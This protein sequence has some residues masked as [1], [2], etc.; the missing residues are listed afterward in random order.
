MLVVGG[1]AAGALGG[2]L[3][4]V[5]GR[6]SQASTSERLAVYPCPETGPSL[7]FISA[8]QQVL[9]T[10]RNEASTWLRIHYPSSGRQEAWVEAGPMTVDGSVASLP[11]EDCQAELAIAPPSLEPEESLTAVENNPPSAGPTATVTPSAGPTPT[12]NVR[13]VVASLTASTNVIS[14]DPGPYCPKAVK[15][16]TFR[17][18]AADT[19][20][21]TGVTLSW[22]EPGSA[23]FVQTAM[24]RVAGN[25]KEGTWQV[26]LNTAGNGIDTA[27]N[28]AFFA[29][30]RDAAGAT[31]RI[32]VSGS[33]S[34]Q[35][36]VCQNTGPTITAVSPAA[37]ASL[38]WDPLGVGCRTAITVAATIK[39]VD[40]IASATL[41][42]RRPGSSTFASKPMTLRSGRFTA[43]L[44]TQGD[45]I[46]IFSPPNDPLRWFIRAV[47]KKGLDR[48]ID[49]R[50]ITIRRCDSEATFL[51]N[52]LVNDFFTTC[53]GFRLG[54]QLSIFDPDEARGASMTAAF[55][56]SIHNL[57]TG[58]TI[59]STLSETITNGTFSIA[60]EA[61][62]STALLGSNTVS[63]TITTKDRYGGTTTREKSASFSVVQ[64]PPR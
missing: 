55:R 26:V 25:A 7:T 35:V 38:S 24:N 9:A 40:G 29:E 21:V 16:V 45:D 57:D 1:I 54:W 19:G 48:Q 61:L 50:T 33:S 18:R 31:R 41:F 36:R 32:P 39:D 14:F 13:P 12:P 8:G 42:F 10:G 49:P 22:R 4:A 20:G 43:V 5:A 47:D 15:S 56:Y 34:I 62:S 46:S 60:S 11:V 58:R 2:G 52:R 53:S 30:A 6:G 28:L 44:N 51:T 63:W 23:S 3:L 59:T 64:C 37:G 27:G 17:V